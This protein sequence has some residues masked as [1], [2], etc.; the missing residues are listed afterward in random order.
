MVWLGIVAGAAVWAVA[1][2]FVVGMSFGL[3]WTGG[4]VLSWTSIGVAWLLVLWVHV[5]RPWRARAWPTAAA[6]L[7]AVSLTLATWF[8]HVVA[9]F[10]R[11][12]ENF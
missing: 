3:W 11:S 12:M 7:F 5:R 6:A 4:V 8:G 10:V 1:W 9:Q 2:Y